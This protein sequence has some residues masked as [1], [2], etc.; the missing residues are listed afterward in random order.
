[1]HPAKLVGFRQIS[2]KDAH[3]VISLK[4]AALFC[5]IKVVVDNLHPD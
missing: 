2:S 5:L 3:G 4:V 1:M